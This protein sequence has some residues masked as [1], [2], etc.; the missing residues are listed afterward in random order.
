[1]FSCQGHDGQMIFIM[2][3]QQLIV[4]VLGFSHKP[5]NTLDFDSLLRD[6]IGTI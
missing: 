2:P 1:M 3:S 4:V 6:I 5:D